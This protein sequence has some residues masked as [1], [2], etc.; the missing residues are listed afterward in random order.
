MSPLRFLLLIIFVL[1]SFFSRGQNDPEKIKLDRASFGLGMGQVYGGFGANFLTYPNK[2]FGLFIGGGYAIVNFGFNVGVKARV[3]SNY[4]KSSISPFA[5]FM[6]GYHTA[7]DI[8]GASGLSKMFYGF[9]FGVGL[10]FS[11]RNSV[12]RKGYWSFA[13]LIPKRSDEV[14]EYIDELKTKHGVRFSN[15][16]SAATISLGYNFIITKK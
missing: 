5:T 7:I 6:Y 12:Q 3:I 8:Q 1:L 10:D 4:K 9:T 13:I 16:R 14:D 2:N 11:F 15:A